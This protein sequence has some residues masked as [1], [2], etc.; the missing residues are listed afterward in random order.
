MN[1]S[2]NVVIIDTFVTLQALKSKQ[3]DHLKS[4]E[5]VWEYM[6]MHVHAYRRAGE[7]FSIYQC[8]C[9]PVYASVLLYW[10]RCTCPVSLVGAECKTD[11][12]SLPRRALW[13]AYVMVKA[14]HSIKYKRCS[15]NC[16]LCLFTQK[17]CQT[18]W[19]C[20]QHLSICDIWRRRGEVK[21]RHLGFSIGLSR[22]AD[23]S[24]DLLT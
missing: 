17:N 24:L 11:R 2:I 13:H 7:L 4:Q 18:L 19:E 6:G 3:K 9:D 8:F 10:S 16:R 20:R 15:L 22:S 21:Y 5:D 14:G 1:G 23:E 12:A